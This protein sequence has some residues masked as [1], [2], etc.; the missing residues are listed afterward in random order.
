[1]VGRANRLLHYTDML[2]FKNHGSKIYDWGGISDSE[3]IRN[4]TDFKSRFG[5]I[6]IDT[7]Y[8]QEAVSLKGKIV[9]ETKK[10]ITKYN[11][12]KNRL[13]NL[14]GIQNSIL[15]YDRYRR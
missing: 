9:L 7:F 1:M 6:E 8:V 4:I 13:V 14:L 5:G 2:F 3:E 12:K 11:N 15:D 10:I